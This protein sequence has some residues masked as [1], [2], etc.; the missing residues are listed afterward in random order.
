MDQISQ[1]LLRLLVVGLRQVGRHVERPLP[2][3][4]LRIRRHVRQVVHHHEHLDYGAQ[5]VEQ[6]HLNC[7]LL[8]N[9][10]TLLAQ[11]DVA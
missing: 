2:Q 9:A 7:S 6:G 11:V 10:V 3:K 5:R 8:R 1:P 4:R